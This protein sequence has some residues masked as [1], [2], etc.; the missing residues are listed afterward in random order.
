MPISGETIPLPSAQLWFENELIAK[1]TD[2]SIQAILTITVDH[3]YSA[4]SGTYGDQTST[5]NLKRGS[6]YAIISDFG[7]GKDGLLLA[8]RQCLLDSYKAN[9]LADTSREVLTET[10]NIIGQTWMQQTTLS[11][12]LFTRLTDVFAIRHHRFGV[13]AQEQG[14]YVDVKTQL[15]STF[16]R[17]GVNADSEAVFKADSFFASAMEHGVLEQLQGVNRPAVSTIRLMHLADSAAKKIFKVNAANFS[18]IS[19]Q[20]NG[21]SA[22]DSQDLQT[23]VNNGATLILPAEGKIVLREWSGKGYVNFQKWDDGK[24]EI[25]MKIDGNYYGGYG[26]LKVPVDTNKVAA[27]YNPEIKPEAQ[28][29]VRT[30]KDPVDFFSGAFLYN[31]EDISLGE[32]EPNGLHFSRSYNSANNNQKG[33]MAGGWTHNYDINVNIHSDV[34][35][36]LGKRQAVDAASFITSCFVSFDLMQVSD[37]ELIKWTAGVLVGKWA[38]DELFE[39]AATIRLDNK[40]L[41][42]IRLS[43]GTYNPPPGVTTKLI[44]ENGLFRLEERFGARVH[45]NADN[46]ISSW[47]DVDGSAMTFTYNAGKLKNVTDCVNRTLSLN[48]TG[49]LLT[50]VTDSTGRSVS[51]GYA[52]GDLT[53]YTDSRNKLWKYGYNGA[54]K[55]TNL[56]NPLGITTAVN[57]YD[58]LG[59]VNTQA[60]PRQSG[61]AA[62]KFYFSGFRNIEE[63]PYGNQTIYYYNQDGLNIGI[64]N[65]LAHKSTQVYDGQNH[66]IEA[67]DNRQNSTLFEYDQ[68]SNL[69]KTKNALSNETT[70]SYDEQFHLTAATDPLNHITKFNYDA[71]HHLIKTT[72]A[73]SNA[74]SMDYYPNGQ[75]KAATDSRGTAAVLTYDSYNNLKTS[76]TGAHSA[77]NYVY[78]T[79]G[80]MTSLTD[81]KGGV[82]SFSYDNRGLLLTRTDSLGKVSS[83]SYDD[84]G[85]MSTYTDRNNKSTSYTYTPTGEL[86][87]VSYAD[88][89][90]VQFTYNLH[91]K[92]T[93][94]KDA[95]GT[96]T[97]NY[98]KLYRLSSVTDAQGFAVS[99]EYDSAGNTT[100][101]TYP[102]NKSVRYTYDKLNRLSSVTNWLDQIAVYTYDRAG[103]LTKLVNFNGAVTTYVY[104]DANR[105]I[106]LK[107][108]DNKGSVIASYSFELDANGNRAQV[109]KDEPIIPLITNHTVDYTYNKEGSRLQT[110]GPLQGLSWDNE[111]QLLAYGGIHYEFDCKHRLTNV[112]GSGVLPAQY[113]YDRADRRL[114]AVRSGVPTRYIYD[115]A[116]N[117]LAEADADNKI[118]R[119]Y[120]YGAGLLAMVTPADK[121]YCYHYNAIGSTIAITDQEQNLVNKYAYAPFGEILNEEE[122]IP[123]PFKFVGRYGV[124]YEESNGLYYMGARYYDPSDGR[125]IS[126]D[127]IGFESGEVNLFAYAGNNP[128]LVIDPLGLCGEK[129]WGEKFLKI[130]QKPNWKTVGIGAIEAVG[131]IGEVVAGVK[132]SAMTAGIGLLIAGSAIQSGIFMTGIGIM[133]ITMGICGSDKSALI[134][135]KD[136]I[137]G[138]P[139]ADRWI[140]EKGGF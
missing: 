24:M 127:P 136:A 123:Q 100:K 4:D 45:F 83:Y 105:L 90:S 68:N 137:K 58:S 19:P 88:N 101:I 31:N 70:D 42:F 81:Q 48:Y 125:F 96:I 57:T 17:D 53:D 104:D 16:S 86:D 80:R 132:F 139:I 66:L 36:G 13:V 110:T 39:N 94:M 91:D 99:Y 55:M 77:I 63:D 38:M 49:E 52:N 30:S 76:T 10:L 21:Y 33:V 50:S 32:E 122:D 60:V 59:R 5:Y 6:S 138:D 62:Y 14:Y 116:G 61:T 121:V 3:P 9:G 140:K 107:N 114:K 44:K 115:I 106:Q 111:G 47:Q 108:Q 133:D 69:I 131:G 18:A 67:I 51:Y 98:D 26:G 72:D 25:G 118:T 74:V 46:K 92:L 112:S 135:I 54:H 34:D 84:T 12:D 23:Q 82:T 85:R 78:D 97:Y 129:S 41:T 40:A 124:M 109:V 95:I 37:T 75:V 20:L 27:E 120:I 89:T 128:M 93:A 113:V 29:P 28:I 43:D 117:L 7:N 130:I 65:A 102:D 56:I 22:S 35:A 15:S 79:L 71:K 103:R 73:E 64:E 126:E 119:Y 1:E 2:S 8:K 87:T 134:L 11:R